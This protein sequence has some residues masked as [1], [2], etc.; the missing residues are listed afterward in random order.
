MIRSGSG[1]VN[2]EPYSSSLP[3]W[4]RTWTIAAPVHFGFFQILL[5]ISATVTVASI[6][7]CLFCIW[8]GVRFASKR[9]GST[10]VAA[11]LPPVSILK[12][13]K[14]SDPEMYEA[15]RSHCLQN[16]PEYE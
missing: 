9:K 15:L 12:P 8:A 1:F 5:L 7:Y 13:V 11:V 3:Q 4:P 2:C 6:G 16:Y 10:I 14:G